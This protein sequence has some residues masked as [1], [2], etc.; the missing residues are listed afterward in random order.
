MSKNNI[1][2]LFLKYEI[3][4]YKDVHVLPATHSE[5]RDT[6][7]IQLRNPLNNL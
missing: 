6:R 3:P 4:K 7:F 2:N 1:L 5:P